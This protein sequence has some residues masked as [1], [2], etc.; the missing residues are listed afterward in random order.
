MVRVVILLLLLAA[1]LG[2]AFWRGGGPERVMAALWLIL[3]VADP[4]IHRIAPLDYHFVDVGHLAIDIIGSAGAFLI[5]L[6][7]YRFWPLIVAPLQFLPL[8]AHMS[9]AIEL[10]MHPSA[11]LIMQVASYWPLTPI[12]IIG[13]WRHYRRANRLGSEPDWVSWSPWL[14][15]GA[16]R[17]T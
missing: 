15:K 17:S 5:A 10:D 2:Y 11:Y 8:L 12:L 3:L 4:L 9:R 1:A 16:S 13:T 6:Y 14:S 7:A